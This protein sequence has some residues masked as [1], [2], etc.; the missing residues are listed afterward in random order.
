MTSVNR[1]SAVAQSASSSSATGGTGLLEV[2]GAPGRASSS[3]AS[4]STG[5]GLDELVV[6][7]LRRRGRARRRSRRTCRRAKLRPVGPRT[8][9][10]PPVMYS[11][12]WS[13]TP[14]TTAGAPELRTQNRSPTSPRR[15]ISPGRRAVADHVA[16]DDLLARRRT[17]P[18][19]RGGPR[20]GRRTGPCRRSRWRRP[21]AAASCPRGTNAPNDW[22]ADPVKVRSMVPS[23]S[24]SP[25]YRLVTSWPRIVPTVRLTLRIATCAAHRLALLEGGLGQ[26]D[27]LGDVERLVEAVVLARAACPAQGR[28]LRQLRLV[29]DRREVEPRGLPVLHRARPRR[30]RRP[31][32]SP[33]RC[34]RK[35][36]SASS[37]RTS[38]AMYSKKFTTYSALPV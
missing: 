25:P 20:S 28:A 32:R 19:G 10:M 33:R 37:S 12:P 6:D 38:S 15:K 29:Q 4:P 14:S 35:P 17:S 36:S 31:G 7:P 24:P 22:P 2:P 34:V 26:R 11:Q 27:Q 16:G 23:G 5:L 8:T 13:P 18:P 1:A 9:T 3:A 21:P 30:A